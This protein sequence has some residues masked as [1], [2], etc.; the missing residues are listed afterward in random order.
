MDKRYQQGGS[1]SMGL[2]PNLYALQVSIFFELVGALAR[3]RHRR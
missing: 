1:W 2:L 3:P